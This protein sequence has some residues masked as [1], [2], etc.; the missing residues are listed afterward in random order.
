V[1]RAG[2]F[3][4]DRKT[5]SVMGLSQDNLQ[6]L[7]RMIHNLPAVVYRFQVEKDWQ[8]DFISNGVSELTGYTAAQL[9]N[10][11]GWFFYRLIH[12][13]DR[14]RVWSELQS[15]AV[16]GSRYRLEYRILS[17]DNQEKWVW[18]YG[19]CFKNDLGQRQIEGMLIDVTE[20]KRAEEGIAYISFHDKLTDLYNRSF[21][22]EEL[23]RVDTPRQLPLSLV[24]V[25][26]N[27]LKLINDVFGHRRGDEF[28][29][30]TA[31]MLRCNCR[32]EDIIS[33][34]GGDEFVIL[35][36]RTSTEAAESVC[37]RIKAAAGSFPDRF[38]HLGVAV[39]CA[40]KEHA[41]VD[42]L[43]VFSEAENNMY[44]HKIIEERSSRKVVLDSLKAK[45]LE[46]E[47]RTED[48]VEN[49]KKLVLGLG[50]AMGLP[51]SQLEELALLATVCNVG[52]LS[53][54]E[55]IINKPSKLNPSEWAAIHK[56]PETGYRIARTFPELVPVAEAILFHHERWDG[57]GYPQGLKGQ[58]I[59]L[60]SRIVAIVQAYDAMTNERP[61][62]RKLEPSQAL[63]EIKSCA[64]SQFDPKLAEAFVNLMSD[65]V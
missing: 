52:K 6:S 2:F 47:Y 5:N 53:I 14:E 37:A 27:G 8:I 13:E 25:D 24:F 46:K 3:S 7:S 12:Y 50:H 51:D 42:I 4:K 22:E 11:S 35:M 30:S 65:K 48:R 56:H 23:R 63:M 39:G 28:L 26:L 1:E 9:L 34:W 36:P 32:K 19:H 62:A 16:P 43:D 40:T 20:H 18:D 44:Q 38:L 17:L 61:F 31:N 41:N 60:L 21:F 29:R 45:I 55:E 58:Q 54:D 64:G 59:P 33:R 49:L 57:K 10:Y 15:A